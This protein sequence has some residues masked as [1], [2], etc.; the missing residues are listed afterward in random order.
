MSSCAA[1]Y[2]TCFRKVSC[3]F[4][5]SASSPTADAPRSCH[6]AFICS[7]QH[8][9]QSKTYPAAKTQVIFGSAQNV[10]DR[11][12]SSRGLL[13]SRSNSVL[14]L[15]WLRMPHETTL[16]STNPLRVSA[17]SVSLC[18]AVLQ[19]GAFYFLKSC[20]HESFEH[21]SSFHFSLSSVV[22][23]RTPPAHL[24]TAASLN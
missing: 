18:L 24:D 17:R 15:P 23:C 9:K 8:R 2:C 13:L 12:R 7:A 16:Y 19:T 11:C 20:L 6:F 1:S 22:L 14:H 4:G 5:T 10:V 3:A 21:S